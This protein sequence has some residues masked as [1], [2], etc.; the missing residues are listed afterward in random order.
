MKKTV[1]IIWISLLSGLILLG[2]TPE[3]KRKGYCGNSKG[4]T[5]MENKIPDLTEDQ[6]EKINDLRIDMFKEIQPV[7][8]QLGEL[9]AAFHTLMTS[10]NPD[11]KA[12]EKN[13]D[14][15]TNLQAELMKSHARYRIA[16]SNLLT[17]DQ[18]VI[19]NSPRPGRGPM[20]RGKQMNRHSSEPA[21]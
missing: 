10:D 19:F 5:R 18:R 6:K 3:G 2:Q 15:R 9:R 14:A 4:V 8:N 1:M 7:R 16:V 12:I 13:I 21:A 11:T 17:D 20:M